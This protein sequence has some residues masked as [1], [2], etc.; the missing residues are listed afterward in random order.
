M[1]KSTKHESVKRQRHHL[2]RRADAISTQ[3]VAE[4]PPD[5]LLSTKEVAGWLGVSKQFLEIG[6]GKGYG[7]RFTRLSPRKI[8]YRRTDV[9]VW[10][11]QRSHASTKE[12]AT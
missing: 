3:P 10:L 12:Y 8:R 5:Q 9:L 2:D 6:R 11:E 1:P 7:P 4:G